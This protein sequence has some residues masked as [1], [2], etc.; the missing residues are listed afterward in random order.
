MPGYRGVD[1]DPAKDFVL[2]PTHSYSALGSGVLLR[3]APDLDVVGD[4]R[5]PHLPGIT[6]ARPVIGAFDLFAITYHLT[7]DAEFVADAIADR[8]T[9]QGRQR[10]HEAGGEATEPPVA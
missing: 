8:R 2:Y 9:L 5:A 10:V 3:M 1:R 4:M 7:E 6:E